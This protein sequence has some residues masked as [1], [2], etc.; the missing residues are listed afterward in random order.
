MFATFAL[1]I[2]YY[3][4]K[5]DEN[6]DF[7][8]IIWLPHEKFNF[9]NPDDGQKPSTS[10]H[11]VEPLGINKVNIKGPIKVNTNEKDIPIKTFNV[12]LDNAKIALKHHYNNLSVIQQQYFK[13]DSSYIRK[14]VQSLQEKRSVSLSRA[15]EDKAV[16]Q[17]GRFL[18]NM[19]NY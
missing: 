17:M 19:N 7:N 15:Q 5:S 18:D 13:N 4:N 2:G 10:M 14:I 6:Y 8:D 1:G 11:Y 9:K 3:L 16:S 12:F